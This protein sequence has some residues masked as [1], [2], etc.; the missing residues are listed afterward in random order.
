M[1]EAHCLIYVGYLGYIE[2]H[3]YFRHIHLVD[4]EVLQLLVNPGNPATDKS[5]KIDRPI[6]FHFTVF[7]N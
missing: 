2:T 6:A 3:H 7:S 5:R 1:K 4:V